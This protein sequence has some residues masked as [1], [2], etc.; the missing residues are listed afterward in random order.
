MER[1]VSISRSG[2]QQG[3]YVMSIDDALVGHLDSESCSVDLVYDQ[4]N[5]TATFCLGL[6]EEPY[7]KVL[8]SSIEFKDA[9]AQQRAGYRWEVH[10]QWCEFCTC[11]VCSDSHPPP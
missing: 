11:L 3:V 9:R 4:R 2:T 1:E 8:H 10:R 7:S 6:T 5:L